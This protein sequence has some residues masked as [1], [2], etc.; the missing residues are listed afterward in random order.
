MTGPCGQGKTRGGNWG[1]TIKRTRYITY[2][3]GEAPL[4]LATRLAQAPPPHK[5]QERKPGRARHRFSTGPNEA[6][7]D[8]DGNPIASDLPLRTNMLRIIARLEG[9]GLM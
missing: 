6:S 9:K 4:G 3:T 7:Q 8:N 1:R 5:P 2:G